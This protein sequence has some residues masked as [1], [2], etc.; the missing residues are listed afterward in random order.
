MD[1]VYRD[2]I[3]QNPGTHLMGG[4]TNDSI[5]Q[6]HWQ[7]LVS[8]HLHAHDVPS[9]AIGKQ[10]VEKVAKELKGIKSSNWN[11]E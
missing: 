4:I 8:F 9:S 3:H 2:Y 5:W 11:S 6:E 7:W 10:F 1:E